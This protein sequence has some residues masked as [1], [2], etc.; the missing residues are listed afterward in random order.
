MA[1]D[2]RKERFAQLI[3]AGSSQT[4]AYKAAGYK[5][6]GSTARSGA[7]RLAAREEV[8]YRIKELQDRHLLE[9][10]ERQADAAAEAGIDVEWLQKKGMELYNRAMEDQDYSAASQTLERIAKISGLWLDRSTS[11]TSQVLTVLSS[12]PLS[13]EEWEQM[14]GADADLSLKKPTRN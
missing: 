11:D 1:L 7:A 14:Y 4:A 12:T 6:E 9:L 5:G 3:A 10:R 13:E 8:K 2:G